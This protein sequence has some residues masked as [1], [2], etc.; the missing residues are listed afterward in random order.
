MVSLA[1]RRTSDRIATRSVVVANGFSAR[2]LVAPLGI[3]VPLTPIR[4]TVAFMQRADYFG[5][6]HPIISD[7]VQGSYYRP[8]EGRSDHGRQDCAV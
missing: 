8:R 7:R 4:H 2:G 5:K 3:E 1:S 6:T